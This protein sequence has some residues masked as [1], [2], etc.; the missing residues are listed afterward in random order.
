MNILLKRLQLSCFGVL[1][2]ACTIPQQALLGPVPIF[3]HSTSTR[4]IQSSAPLLLSTMQKQFQPVVV[5]FAS[6]SHEITPDAKKDLTQFINRLN[7]TILPAIVIE[8][9]T[10][11]N[12]SEDYNL[13]LAKQRVMSVKETLI[14]SGYPDGQVIEIAKGEVQPIASN[15]TASGRQLNRRVV[16]KPYQE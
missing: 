5:Y 8:G 1:V 2:S 16:V 9:H 11:A 13:N 4:E 3:S 12:D 7:H 14:Q 6:D 15:A 10:D